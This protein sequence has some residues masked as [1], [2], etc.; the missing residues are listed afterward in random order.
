MAIDFTDLIPKATPAPAL[1]FDDL[2]PQAMTPA[3]GF[4][5]APEPGLMGR[6]GNAWDTL[7]G[8]DSTIERPLIARVGDAG[9]QVVDALTPDAFQRGTVTGKQTAAQLLQMGG[10]GSGLAAHAVDLAA[11]ERE[12][13]KFPQDP[14]NAAAAKAMS[15]A[16]GLGDWAAAATPGALGDVVMESLG[17]QAPVMAASLAGGPLSIGANAAG[18]LAMEYTGAIRQ[19]MAEQGVDL[20]DASAVQAFLADPAKMESA[21]ESGLKRGVPIAAFDA[22]TA[23]VAGKLFNKSGVGNAIKRSVTDFV[24]G[25]GGGMAGEATA[26]LAD[27]GEITSVGDILT[28][29]VAEGPSGVL[30]GIGN[31]VAAARKPATPIEAGAQAAQDA[32]SAARARRGGTVPPTA[33]ASATPAP[34]TPAAPAGLTPAD[35]AELDAN[36]SGIAPESTADLDAQLAP[37]AL[38]PKPVAPPVIP[39]Q[40]TASAT[41]SAAPGASSESLG[42]VGSDATGRVEPAGSAGI[43]AVRDIQA[44]DA[45]VQVGAAGAEQL[46]PQRAALDQPALGVPSGAAEGRVRA[47][48]GAAVAPVAVGE[49]SPIAGALS[50]EQA[51]A[52]LG[53]GREPANVRDAGRGLPTGER[54]LPN[55]RE[56]GAPIGEGGQGEGLAPPGPTAGATPQ[57][58]PTTPPSSGV[59][60]SDDAP[61]LSTSRDTDQALVGA[62]RTLA[63]NDEAFQTP[64]VKSSDMEGI[65]AEIDP[66]VR[67]LDMGKAYGV[68]GAYEIVLPGMAPVTVET[69]QSDGELYV[70]A[71][72]LKPGQGGAKVYQIVSAFAA[73]NGLTFKGDPHGLSKAALYRRTEQML[74]SA[75]KERGTRH[76]RP[77]PRQVSPDVEGVRP[78]EWRD[79]DEQHNLTELVKSS[80]DNFRH[81]VPEIENVVFV[82]ERK[83]FE[84]ADGS[85]PA[86][87]ARAGADVEQGQPRFH[88]AVV[89]DG[90]FRALGD[91]FNSRIRGAD[92]GV[93]RAA[94]AGEIGDAPNA[95][96][97]TAK[98]AAV[99]ATVVRRAR[100][101]DWPA[102]LDALAGQSGDGLTPILHRLLYSKA[103]ANAGV[104]VS[105]PAV[106]RVRRAVQQQFAGYANAP[107]VEVVARPADLA[108]ARLR[109]TALDSEEDGGAVEG[110]FDPRTNT[111]ALFADRLQNPARARWVA[112]HE[113]VGHYGIR[114]LLD[115]SGKGTGSF[116][117]MLKEART[118]PTIAALATAVESDRGLE[119]NPDLATEEALAELAAADST[120]EWHGIA[121]RYGVE[122]PQRMRSGIRAAIARFIDRLKR[123]F[124][125]IDPSMG[126]FT[127][128]DWRKL[129]TGARRYVRATPKAKPANDVAAESTPERA[130]PLQSAPKRPQSPAG[131]GSG[132]ISGPPA[133]PD[134]RQF[135]TP[136]ARKAQGIMEKAAQDV[137]D[138]WAAFGKVLYGRPRSPAG[139]W[140]RVNNLRASIFDSVMSR[141]R[142]IE[143]R[144]PKATSLR[145]LFNLAMAAPGDSRFVAETV[146]D[147]IAARFA[148]FTNRVRNVLQ[149][150]NLDR[151]TE[152][153]NDQLRAEMLGTAKN[154]PPSIRNAAEKLRRLM[155][156]QREDLIA[157]G[158]DVGT[159]TD[160]GY[161]TRMYDEAKILTDEKGFLAAAQEQ[162]AKH[163][164][165]REVGTSGHNILYTDRDHL[166]R[167]LAAARRAGQ[168]DPAV[169]SKLAEI[170]AK[171]KSYRG[172]SSFQTVREIEALVDDIY[173]KV[174]ESYG[175]ARA[176][177]WLHSIKT[178]DVAQ[179]VN[180]VGP[181][182]AP[183]TKARTLSGEADTV[184]AAYLKTDMLDI[185]DTYGRKVAQ[186][187]EHAKRFGPKGEQLQRLIDAASREGVNSDDLEQVVELINSALGLK[188]MQINKRIKSLFDFIH[189]L[190]YLALL[191]K[192]AF[193]SIMEAVTFSIRTGNLKHT[194]A[195]LIQ[196]VRAVSKSK[197]KY[198][199]ELDAL[200]LTIGVNGH[201]AVEAVLINRLGGDYAMEPRWSNI[202]H[203]FFSANFLAPITRAQRAYGVGAATGFLRSLA[204]KHRRGGDA[205]TAA[206][207]NEL[208]I[209][210]HDAFSDWLLSQGPLPDPRQL[211]DTNGRPTPR[212]QDYM[213]AV[214]RVVDQSI[215]NPSAAH[216]PAWTN[217]PAGRLVTGIMSFSY[218]S[219]ENVI[220]GTLRRAKRGDGAGH[221]MKRLAAPL[222]GA[223]A[224]VLAQTIAS[225]LREVLF[226]RDRLEDKDPD[227]LA[228]ELVAL[229]LSRTFGLGSGDPILQYLTGLKY[230]RSLSEVALGAVPGMLAQSADTIA[231]LF[232]ERNSDNTETA[233]YRAGQAFFRVVLAPAMNMVLSR[234]PLVGGPALIA[235]SDKEVANSFGALFGEK[236][237]PKTDL[238]RAYSAAV[239]EVEEIKS[240]LEDRIALL[241]KDQWADELDKLKAEYPTILGDVTLDTY[242]DNTQNRNAGKEGPKATKDG[243]P[244]LKMGSGDVGSVLGE[245]EGYPYW[246]V[247]ERKEKM[248]EGIQDR[249]DLLNKSIK[250]LRADTLSR[251][252]LVSFVAPVAPD[253]PF[254]AA[255][256]DSDEPASRAEITEAREYLMQLRRDEKRT[257]IDVME[258]AQRGEPI[259]RS[260]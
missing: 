183:V 253:A 81:V 112:A 142:A 192:A 258:R 166:A 53:A 225:T 25:A 214:R 12:K 18:S 194:V 74:S 119:R 197:N 160:V 57:V 230:Q 181:S 140:H 44:A 187:I 68:Q 118:N 20:E 221:A 99:T 139:M 49:A 101:K 47:V 110:M 36:L 113:I 28:E 131:D 60:L 240:Q 70:D 202:L 147:A 218:A 134:L 34:A 58:T 256:P 126:S 56:Q 65:A 130:T 39:A 236:P 72:R 138:Q 4:S 21:K 156:V 102:I 123:L 199:K 211:F 30:E 153:Q 243:K 235:L 7:T 213:V 189:T 29:G 104:S 59:S 114:G 107:K 1:S 108:D 186:K 209:S 6:L 149:F 248:S 63:Q 223:V 196:V 252:A 84:W 41:L 219:Y 33:P 3:P 45:G 92:S 48:E 208:G 89:G 228:E 143:A 195:P 13:Q 96:R 37:P 97:D 159:V 38:Q 127:D 161:L 203:R 152:A 125:A 17:Q 69:D 184:M 169:A 178:P 78:I 86:G 19:A 162:Y 88:G 176:S 260:E 26:Q 193:S 185:L 27:K 136:Q 75:L 245:L 91:L 120:G 42:Q 231:N 239:R 234:I 55:G 207:L 242:V 175:D 216:R 148:I 8:Q 64:R 52:S 137:R 173:A 40:T 11:L 254:L 132:G 238:D 220:K 46:V 201:Q 23:G 62:W 190:G 9:G 154:S 158:V 10:D 71:S 206:H 24:T 129:V 105:G 224:L 255:I 15:E 133:P 232:T 217:N 244:K 95:G 200:A 241:P 94:R 222:G 73:K 22:V 116:G 77:H 31:V 122:V 128:A 174:A 205:D 79:G 246:D 5:A 150:Y 50:D 179:Y 191:P 249:I 124:G 171:I 237:E 2:I 233:E 146:N 229:G 117:R 227:E 121:E 43:P 115:A 259:P 76:L 90:D 98:R 182:G 35:L 247:Y 177:A 204:V 67:V 151:M 111:V 85:P 157:A 188:P 165:P 170:K 109:L 163:E 82:P 250:N 145:T 61:R 80:Y 198:A 251:T 226:N 215:Q 32:L 172:T 93:R 83:Q 14:A 164:F 51:A 103:P 16:K 167:F 106:S 141:A 144:N 100:S 135:D 87:L 212:G 54:V 210:D 168:S 66:E 155:D 257:A 180:G